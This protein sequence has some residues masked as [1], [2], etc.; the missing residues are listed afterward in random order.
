ML[1]ASGTKF[2]IFLA[3]FAADLYCF[4]CF[5]YDEDGQTKCRSREN[6]ELFVRKCTTNSSGEIP[7]CIS[8][9]ASYN[10][11]QSIRGTVKRVS[12]EIHA[13]HCGTRQGCQRK[14]C[15]NF[16]P[17]DIAVEECKITCCES[18]DRDN[19]PF[20]LPSDK[21]IA[22]YKEGNTGRANDANVQAGARGS[23]MTRTFLST[24]LQVLCVSIVVKHAWDRAEHL[25]S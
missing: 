3:V 15:P 6:G 18:K 16:W 13:V 22:D 14:E 17:K 20:P 8:F 2:L 12:T 5:G 11:P 1:P 7:A 23:G 10:I 19:C 25:S 9:D 24:W 21:D 4:S